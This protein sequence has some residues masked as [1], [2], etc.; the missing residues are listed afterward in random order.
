MTMAEEKDDN[1]KSLTIVL[2][3]VLVTGK[4]PIHWFLGELGK[5]VQGSMMWRTY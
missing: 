2:G 4:P 3:T 5:V 1:G